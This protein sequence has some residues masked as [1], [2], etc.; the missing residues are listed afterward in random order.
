[1]SE[2][3]EEAEDAGESMKRGAK[4]QEIDLKKVLKKPKIK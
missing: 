3:K 2:I 1:M 4:K